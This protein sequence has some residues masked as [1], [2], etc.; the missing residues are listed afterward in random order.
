MS[1]IGPQYSGPMCAGESAE[2]EREREDREDRERYAEDRREAIKEMADI[3]DRAESAIVALA[4]V[5]EPGG[6]PDAVGDALDLLNKARHGLE[7]C[8]P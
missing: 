7:E 6:E 8:A 3:L 2:H 5:F 1:Y 4:E